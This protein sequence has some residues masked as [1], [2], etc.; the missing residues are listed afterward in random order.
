MSNNLVNI[1]STEEQG[2][3]TKALFESR[4]ISI[5]LMV[6][7]LLMCAIFVVVVWQFFGKDP[8]IDVIMFT[9]IGVGAGIIFTIVLL[10]IFK[11]FKFKN[12]RNIFLTIVFLILLI[13][14]IISV[15]LKFSVSDPTLGSW[16]FINASSTGLGVTTG[17]ALTYLILAIFGSNLIE[18]QK[19][20]Q[21]EPY[22][23][24][25]LEN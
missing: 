8:A 6:T 11:R 9:G 4:F 13:S 15:I 2:E 21:E 7:L 22:E 17:I 24:N 23:S 10:F 25:N 18:A 3:K 20:E 16:Y 19:G 1:M 5:V 14:L 12:Q